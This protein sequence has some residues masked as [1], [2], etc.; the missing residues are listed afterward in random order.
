MSEVENS[1]CPCPFSC[2]RHGKCSECQ[3][4]HRECGGCTHCGK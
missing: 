2:E 1:D 4:Y 3:A